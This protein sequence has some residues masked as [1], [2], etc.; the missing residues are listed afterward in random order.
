MKATFLL[1]CGLATFFHSFS[2]QSTSPVTSA[3]ALNRVDRN[4][5]CVTN[6][7]VRELPDGRLE[8][9]T[10][11]SRGV[12]RVTTAQT[13]EIR[14]RYMGPSQGSKPLASGELRRQI[15][16]KLRAQDTCNLVY[17]MWHIE[18]DSRIAVS[19]K[20]NAG[21]RTHE[22]CGARGYVNIKARTFVALP[23]IL[24]GES[25]TLRAEL[26]GTDLSL[27]ADQ[28]VVWEG[29]LPP[30]IFDFDGPVGFRT[31]NARFVFE[32]YV[33]APDAGALSNARGSRVA[34]CQA[35]PGD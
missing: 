6:G 13:A 8:I 16:L 29:T 9:D 25:H 17:A 27:V 10:P 22:E 3:P 18:P 23:G 28:R 14:F 7:A 19:V 32:Y 2:A 11:S 15:G 5:I 4:G 30:G 20:R 34:P 1:T 31:D 12:V 24:R 33:A 35:S 21:K 26:H